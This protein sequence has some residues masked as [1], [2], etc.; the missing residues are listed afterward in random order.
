MSGPQRSSLLC[1]LFA[2]GLMGCVVRTWPTS[3]ESWEGGFC[4]AGHRERMRM[5][6]QSLMREELLGWSLQTHTGLT[7]KAF[8][9]FQEL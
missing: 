5:S 4:T 1:Q 9:D 7:C 2:S 8:I 6:I 3:L